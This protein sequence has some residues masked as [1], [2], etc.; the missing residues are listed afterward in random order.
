M[1]ETYELPNGLVLENVHSARLCEGWACV[2]HR[3]TPHHMAEWPLHWRDDR[4][5][6]ERIC[7]HGIGHPDPDQFDYW[8]ATD[9]TAQGIHGCD[10]DCFNPEGVPV[11]ADSNG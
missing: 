3:P 11:D 4:G 10:G 9:Q 2:I 1:S 5:I 7:E 8:Y 6:F